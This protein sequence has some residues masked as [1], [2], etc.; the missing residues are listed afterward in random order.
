MRP[1]GQMYSG[2]LSEGLQSMALNAA[3]AGWTVWQCISGNWITG[4]L[5]GGV[6]LNATFMGGM[7]RSAELAQEYNRDAMRAF[8][9]SFR[10]LLRSHGTAE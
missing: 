1:L 3:A 9:D 2:H 6:A 8:N 7:Q 5:G 10:S 4:L